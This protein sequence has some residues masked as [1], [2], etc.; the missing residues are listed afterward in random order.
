MKPI[1]TVDVSISTLTFSSQIQSSSTSML[2][3]F[4]VWLSQNPSIKWRLW[5]HIS[6]IVKL[7]AFTYKV[8]V[9]DKRYCVWTFPTLKVQALKLTEEITPR[10]KDARSQ[11]VSVEFMS[12]QLSHRF[13]W[14]ISSTIMRVE[15]SL[16]QERCL[17]IKIMQPSLE[18]SK[19]GKNSYAVTLWFS[20]TR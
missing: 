17:T 7:W 8:R 18:C 20:L 11:E 15:S 12:Y 6:I 19:T 13:S 1:T 3:V 2:A 16:K 4:I 9:Q 14:I 10:S 5:I